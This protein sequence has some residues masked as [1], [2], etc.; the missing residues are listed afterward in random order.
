MGPPAS[1]GAPTHPLLGAGPS[2]GEPAS[3]QGPKR[4]APLFPPR[5]RAIQEVSRGAAGLAG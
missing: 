3:R 5:T 2:P 1:A 4:P